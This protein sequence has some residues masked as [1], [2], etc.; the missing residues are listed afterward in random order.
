M[1]G[2]SDK[3]SG[4]IVCSWCKKVLGTSTEFEGTSH[5]ICPECLDKH[6]SK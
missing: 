4:T 2:A 3:K 6:Y 5:G 1:N